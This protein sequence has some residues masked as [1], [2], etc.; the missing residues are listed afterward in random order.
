MLI[1]VI[2]R[3][4][5]GK[6]TFANLLVEHHGFA[7]RSFADTVREVAY[8]TNPVIWSPSLGRY[9]GLARLVDIF[10]WEWVKTN[11]DARGYLQRHGEA[12]R[13]HLDRDTWIAP[14]L[15]EAAKHERFVIPDARYL[16]EID[17]I[18]DAGGI[19]VEIERSGLPDDDPHISEHE[20]RAC[21]PDFTVMNDG[22]VDDLAEF[23]ARTV[24]VYDLARRVQ[25]LAPR[26][27]HS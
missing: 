26:H 3:K 12:V 4:R 6:D 24:Q 27:R 16:N 2:G 14:V 7:R 25:D 5:S 13:E 10:G 15:A 1:G 9:Y 19:V 22:S 8:A 18:R 11:T 17:A 20:W 21:V 23:A